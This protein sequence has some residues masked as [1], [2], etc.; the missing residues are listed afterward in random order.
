MD[1]MELLK[2]ARAG[3]RH[4]RDQMVE[5][6]VGLVW[7]IV[8]RFNGRGYDPEDLFQIGCIGLIKAIDHFNL[9]FDVKFSTYAVPMI[10]GEIKRFMRDD[11]MIKI[12]RTMKEN[13]WKVK[14][15]PGTP[16]QWTAPFSPSPNSLPYLLGPGITTSTNKTAETINA[17]RAAPRKRW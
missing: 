14:L 9:E 15:V 2:K 8:K 16:S 10:M 11:G 6:N 13:G 3:D 4:A 1:A 12:S 17:I 5:E 7:N